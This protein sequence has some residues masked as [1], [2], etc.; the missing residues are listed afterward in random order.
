MRIKLSSL[1][2]LVQ[3]TSTHWTTISVAHASAASVLESKTSATVAAYFLYFMQAITTRVRFLFFR[4]V[5]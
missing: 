2:G 3:S 4:E 1:L 5:F